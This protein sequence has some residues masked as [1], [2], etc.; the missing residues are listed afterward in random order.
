M[1]WM[2]G[3]KLTSGSESALALAP[4]TRRSPLVTGVWTN[5]ARPRGIHRECGPIARGP[6]VYTG[7]VDQSGEAQ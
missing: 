5:R 2:L 7:S 1:V 6:G 3:A 4:S